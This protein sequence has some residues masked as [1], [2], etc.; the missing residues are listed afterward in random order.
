MPARRT[1]EDTGRGEELFVSYGGPAW[2]KSRGIPLDE[3]E[4]S[5]IP[6]T[7]QELQEVI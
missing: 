7:D 1:E 2:F 4:Y 5:T 3:G 6:Y